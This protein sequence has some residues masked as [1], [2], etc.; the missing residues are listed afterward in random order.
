ME[1]P[2]R[3]AA[4]KHALRDASRNRAWVCACP[5]CREARTDSELV[6]EIQGK[7]RALE[8]PTEKIEK[9]KSQVSQ[10]KQSK[11]EKEK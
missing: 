3:D 8:A 10:A 11:T 2:I 7:L 4:L 9:D 6:R 1:T 5:V